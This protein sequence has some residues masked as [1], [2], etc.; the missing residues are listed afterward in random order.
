MRHGRRHPFDLGHIER[1]PCASFCARPGQREAFCRWP[2]CGRVRKGNGLYSATGQTESHRPHRPLS[3]P[4]NDL[5]CGGEDV[6]CAVSGCV[7]GQR[8]ASLSRQSICVVW[9]WWVRPEKGRSPGAVQEHKTYN[10]CRSESVLVWKRLSGFE[11][12]QRRP[13]ELACCWCFVA[14]WG[15]LCVCG[16]TKG[17]LLH[18]LLKIGVLERR[19]VLEQGHG[20]GASGVGRWAN[21]SDAKS[22]RDFLSSLSVCHRPPWTSPLRQ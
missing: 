3:A 4:V 2:G 11:G 16:G 17:Q 7:E 13:C 22:S 1:Q 5:V 10:H 18:S 15:T 12:R 21:E 6:F 20:A 19:T 8:F 9:W 14:R